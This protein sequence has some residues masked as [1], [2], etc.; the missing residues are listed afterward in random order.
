MMRND[1]KASNFKEFHSKIPVWTEKSHKKPKRTKQN[2]R[3]SSLCEENKE[4]QQADQKDHQVCRKELI[5]RTANTNK[6]IYEIK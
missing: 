1:F 4:T 3:P 5:T 2:R 6:Y